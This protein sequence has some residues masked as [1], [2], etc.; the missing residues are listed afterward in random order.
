LKY[1]SEVERD[2]VRCYFTIIFDILGNNPR[3][4]CLYGSCTHGDILVQKSSM[5]SDIDLVFP[6]DTRL[7]FNLIDSLLNETYPI[8]LESCDKQ[9]HE[10]MNRVV[11]ESK[12][13]YC[14]GGLS[15]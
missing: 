2:R 3:E 14:P 7:K 5:H 15:A 6:T 4:I 8:Y 10:F 12:L 11:N 1:L 9:S 13:L